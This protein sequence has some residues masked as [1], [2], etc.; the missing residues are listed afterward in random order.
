[1]DN[2]V[3]VNVLEVGAHTT[4]LIDGA[5]V[6]M[7]I[8]RDIVTDFS[9]DEDI[10]LCDDDDTEAT[11]P[12]TETKQARVQLMVPASNSWTLSTISIEVVDPIHDFQT[13]FKQF[14]PPTEITRLIQPIGN[15]LHIN[16]NGPLD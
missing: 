3:V 4:F 7:V 2:I 9:E 6:K 14:P 12:A 5:K 11:E 13:M 15:I 8:I 10:E 16:S 1:M